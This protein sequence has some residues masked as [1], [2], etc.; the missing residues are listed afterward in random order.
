MI[1]FQIIVLLV[2]LMFVVAFVSIIRHRRGL[3]PTTAVIIILGIALVI[4]VVL[5]NPVI[6]QRIAELIGIGRGADLAIYLAILFLLLASFIN[7]TRIRKMYSKMVKIA[8]EVALSN[9]HY[10]ENKTS[11]K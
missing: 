10:P 9:V 6:T 4:A 2:L 11:N 1:I 7:Y 5:I 8:R 3:I